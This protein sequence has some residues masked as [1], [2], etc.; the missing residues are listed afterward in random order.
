MYGDF[1][2]ASLNCTA[3]LHI[4]LK[5]DAVPNTNR[6]TG[7]AIKR[8]D[9]TPSRKRVR[10]DLF[11]LTPES[12][13]QDTSISTPYQEEVQEEVQEEAKV[14]QEHAATIHGSIVSEVDSRVEE[15]PSRQPIA[16]TKLKTRSVHIQTMQ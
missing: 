16:S 6:E 9:G 2:K 8:S 10:R 4:K 11:T 3:G 15:E 1:L 12:D 13:N 7:E 14:D 5:N